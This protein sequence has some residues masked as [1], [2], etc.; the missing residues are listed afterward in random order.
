MFGDA[1]PDRELGFDSTSAGAMDGGPRA[2]CPR[3]FRGTWRRMGTASSVK[4]DRQRG[5]SAL[6]DS[7]ESPGSSDR[8]TLI[9][10]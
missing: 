2:A 5:G 3:E 1:T 4:A 8:G 7:V 9:C 10:R 6:E